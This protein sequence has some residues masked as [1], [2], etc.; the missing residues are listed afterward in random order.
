MKILLA[1]ATGYIGKRLLPVLIESG[2][3][4]ICC[5]R[6]RNR[7]NPDKS[8]RKHLEVIEVDFLE[9]DTLKEIPKDIDAAYYLLH[10]MSASSNYEELELKCAV[11]FREVISNTNAKQVIYLSGIVNEKSLSRHLSSRKAVEFELAKGT[12]HFTTLRAGII[13]GS[14]S[15]SFEII[16]TSGCGIGSD[17]G[18]VS[19]LRSIGTS[20]PR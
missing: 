1:G 4:V 18:R 20:S 7:F 19:I 6:D 3:S 15:A 17:A 14:G 8:L 16:T 9:K 12:Y 13:I 5:V 11:N 10:S 2:H